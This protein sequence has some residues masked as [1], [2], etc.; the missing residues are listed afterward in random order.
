L[1]VDFR[2][3]RH[4]TVDTK[5]LFQQLRLLFEVLDKYDKL[6]NNLIIDKNG[7]KQSSF[8]V[9]VPE[10]G[11]FICVRNKS[12]ID[13]KL[14]TPTNTQGLSFEM[15]GSY[16]REI[17]L[18]LQKC[19]SELTNFDIQLDS[20]EEKL[21]RIRSEDADNYQKKLKDLRVKK[22]EIEEIE[23]LSKTRQSKIFKKIKLIR[24]EA[25]INRRFIAA[26]ITITLIFIGL[27]IYRMFI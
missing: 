7:Y 2:S 12:S 22:V 10:I 27:S 21:D 6:V 4:F 3:S 16:F 18:Q 5:L 14:E 1:V 11:T 24:H 9:T 20:K 26:L 8:K 13:I 23:A 15:I 17:N 19:Q 25:K